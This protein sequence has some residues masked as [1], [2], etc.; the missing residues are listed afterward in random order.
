MAVGCGVAV[1]VGRLS[2]VLQLQRL[3]STRTNMLILIFI[4]TILPD[5][6]AAVRALMALDRGM[7][8]ARLQIICS[9]LQVQGMGMD[10]AP[11]S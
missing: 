11:G 4:C 1:E 10:S 3:N 2:A 9:S 8:L 7:R 6:L 5:N